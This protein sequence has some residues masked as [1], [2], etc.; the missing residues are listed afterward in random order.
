M[1]EPRRQ[2]SLP[3]HARMSNGP[4]CHAAR[5]TGYASTIP[6]Q[7]AT[8]ASPDV[9]PFAETRPHQPDLRSLLYIQGRSCGCA[10]SS[11]DIKARV[12]LYDTFCGAASDPSPF[13]SHA[14][15]HAPASLVH[16]G[17]SVRHSR[18]Q[19]THFRH[20][21]I[22]SPGRGSNSNWW[23][24]SHSPKKA[25]HILSPRSPRRGLTLT[26]ALRFPPFSLDLFLCVI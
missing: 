18:S 8:K 6:G 11:Y 3:R 17:E 19:I 21:L 22:A 7:R 13:N 23:R 4:Q 12:F 20:R 2:P 1:L 9:L 16:T 24:S 14:L 25:S 10:P 15:Q 5:F 26:T